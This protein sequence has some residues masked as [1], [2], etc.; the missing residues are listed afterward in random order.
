M[1]ALSTADGHFLW[2]PQ[3][4]PNPISFL[5]G[6]SSPQVSQD[7]VIVGYASGKVIKL[8]LRSGRELWSQTITVPEGA[9]AIQRMTDIDADP[10]ISGNKVFVATYQGKVAALDFGSGKILWGP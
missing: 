5:R 8:S 7:A 6:A 3:P 4:K 1:T 10:V 2:S 9:F